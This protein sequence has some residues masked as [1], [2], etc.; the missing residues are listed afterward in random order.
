MN[1]LSAFENYIK[2]NQF[3][4]ASFHPHFEQALNYML[5]AGGKHF[6]AQLILQIVELKNPKVLNEAMKV[7]FGIEIF[8]TYSLIHDDLPAMDNSDL[9]RGKQTLHKKYDEVT[10][11][12]IGDA[13]NTQAFYEISTSNF[14]AELKIEIIQSLSFNGGINGMVIGQALDC[15]FEDKKL[16]LRELEFLHIKKTGALI[17]S[18]MQI[19]A[20]IAGFKEDEIL[21]IYNCGLKLGLAFQ[22]YDD[23]IDVSLSANEAGKPVN[24]DTNKNTF[25]N[26]MSQEEAKKTKDKLIKE[27]MSELEDI[28]KDL[29]LRISKLIFK[30]L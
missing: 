8:H 26:L 13:L 24:N 5:N 11:I 21:K 2:N 27:V 10:A 28:D 17:A 20:M 14:D 16:S 30:Y 18:S 4:I 12:L 23:L 6:R 3:K 9:R 29:A 22:I 7:A 19:G 1:L 15:F 25:T